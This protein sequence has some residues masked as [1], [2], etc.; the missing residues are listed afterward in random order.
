MQ[1]KQLSISFR[2]L[3]VREASAQKKVK[4]R[5]YLMQICNSKPVQQ[6]CNT[7]GSLG[8]ADRD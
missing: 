7:R 2:C 4:S 8:D 6:A 5:R 3:S 1:V